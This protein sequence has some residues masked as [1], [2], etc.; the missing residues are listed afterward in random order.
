MKRHVTCFVEKA[1]FEPMSL[2]TKAERYDHCATRLVWSVYVLS[3][4]YMYTFTWNAGAPQLQVSVPLHSI[5]LRKELLAKS[6]EGTCK[7]AR[8]VATNCVRVHQSSR[9]WQAVPCSPSAPMMLIKCFWC[10][11]FPPQESPLTIPMALFYDWPV[12]HCVY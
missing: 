9:T 3:D 11:N 7:N 12:L 5:C 4:L 8:E 1:G 10:S 2:G 6:L